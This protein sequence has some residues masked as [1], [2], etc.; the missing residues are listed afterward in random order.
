MLGYKLVLESITAPFRTICDNAGIDGEVTWW[1]NL[2]KEKLHIGWDVSENLKTDM[3]EEGIIDPTRVTR[4]AVEKAVS[5][6]G[7]ML[8]TECV[9]T[10]IPKEDTNESPVGFG[11]M[12]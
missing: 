11:N 5:V 3:Y 2:D 6:A 10:K 7:T 12:Q 9:I 4:T 8:I 1:V